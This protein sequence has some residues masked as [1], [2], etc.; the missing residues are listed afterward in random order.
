M[1]QSVFY[2]Y[3]P[4]NISKRQGYGQKKKRRKARRKERRSSLRSWGIYPCYESLESW[5]RISFTP[6]HNCSCR[7]AISS[8]SAS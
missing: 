6:S 1:R 8:R 5:V 3:Y 2:P 7:W 4:S